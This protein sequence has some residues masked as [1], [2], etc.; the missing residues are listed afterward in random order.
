MSS[1]LTAPSNCLA[2][3]KSTFQSVRYA[4]SHRTRAVYQANSSSGF[5]G[6]TAAKRNA[7][8]VRN[9]LLYLRMDAVLNTC[10]EDVDRAR[11]FGIVPGVM[12]ESTGSQS[13][14]DGSNDYLYRTSYFVNSLPWLSLS[15]RSVPASFSA[16]AS[17]SPAQPW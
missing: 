1:I 9:V 2:G 11:H 14:S 12:T 6:R 5:P 16:R 13:S 7:F 10:R 8:P 3:H 17:A 4:P 15:R